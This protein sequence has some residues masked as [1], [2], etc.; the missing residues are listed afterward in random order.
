MKRHRLWFIAVLALLGILSLPAMP[1]FGQR[2]TGNSTI[3]LPLVIKGPGCAAL[4]PEE[5]ALLDFMRN[6]PEQ[7]RPM[8]N[9]DPILQRVA[10]ERALDMGQRNYFSHTNPD[11][12]GPNYLVRQAGYPLPSWYG[13]ALDANNIES[14]AACTSCDAAFVWQMWMNS[15]MH[16][17]HILGL[18]P[19]F[20]EQTD[21]GIGYA[22]VPGSRYVHYWVI[23]TARRAP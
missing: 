21:Y 16:R 3:Y 17:R 7:K 6:D 23:I 8:L 20:A 4:S 14:I 10:R 19:F 1:A 12:Y 15:P 11:G 9:C 18:D 13:Q 22:D 5:Q 2:G